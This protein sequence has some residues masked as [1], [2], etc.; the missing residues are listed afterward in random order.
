MTGLLFPPSSSSRLL[1][2]RC[3]VGWHL[4][5]EHW[6]KA[7]DRLAQQTKADSVAARIY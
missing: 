7:E 4:W 6:R 1:R 2:L 5:G 3:A